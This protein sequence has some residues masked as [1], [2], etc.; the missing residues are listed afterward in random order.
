MMKYNLFCKGLGDPWVYVYKCEK[1]VFGEYCNIVKQ[2]PLIRTSTI[3]HILLL[4]KIIINNLTHR[5]RYSN[6]QVPL[7]KDSDYKQ[8]YFE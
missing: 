6:D 4:V 3:I 7:K 2:L 1:S 5:T 8:P